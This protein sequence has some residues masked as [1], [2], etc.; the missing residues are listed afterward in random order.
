[1]RQK[2]QRTSQDAGY[3]KF[4][5]PENR[6]VYENEEKYGTAQKDTD[7][8]RTRRMRIACWKTKATDTQSECV[9][10]IAFPL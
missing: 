5:P 3:V 2:L 8:N 4:F 7:G 9:I 6:A 1:L 10:L